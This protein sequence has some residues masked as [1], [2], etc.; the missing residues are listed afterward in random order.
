MNYIIAYSLGFA[1]TGA[2]IM[3]VVLL[4]A[5]IP[6]GHTLSFRS[7]GLLY[8]EHNIFY[9]LNLIPLFLGIAG[10]FVGKKVL[11]AKAETDKKISSY[12]LTIDRAI[13]FVRQIENGNLKTP[14]VSINGEKVLAEALESMRT[15]LIT[16]SQKE[17]ERNEINRISN[18][19]STLLQSFSDTGRLSEEIITFLVNKINNVVQGAFYLIE[20]EKDEEKII[21]MSSSYAYNRKK[22]LHAEFKFA[23]GLVGQAVAEKDSVLRTEIPDDY[24]TI[25]SGL[26]GDQKPRCILIMPCI[27]NDIVYCVIELAS[28]HK[29]DSF[30]CNLVTELSKIIARAIANVEINQRTYTLFKESEKMS[31]ELRSQKKQLMK[32]TEDLITTQEELKRSNT[33]L[34]EQIQE[35]HNTSKRT[36]V[37]LENAKEVITIISADRKILY[38]SPSIKAI[39]GYYPEELLGKDDIENVHPL[40]TQRFR[41]LLKDLKSFPEKELTLQYRYFTK[42]G[43]V[44]WMEAKGKNLLS[45]EVIRGFVI[46]SSDISEQR[47]AA[48]EQRMRAKMQ[49]LSENSSDIII[50][51]DIF[52]RCTYIN[53]VIEE[54]TGVKKEFYLDKPISNTQMDASVVTILKNL[55]EEA[56]VNRAKKTAEMEFP[57]PGGRKVMQVNAIPEFN[58]NGEPE[59]VL[60]AC[61]DITEAKS[62]EELIRKK[63]KNIS[64]SINYAFNIQS[65][66]MP[67][68][69]NFHKVLPNSFMFYKPKDVV[70]GDYPWLYK[71]ENSIFVGAMDCTG[72]GV[73]GALMSIIGFFLQSAIMNQD[74]TLNAGEVLTRLHSSVVKILKQEEANSKINDGMDAAFCKI[75][76]KEKVLDFAGAHR[77]LYYVSKGVLTEIRGDKFPVGGTQ[78][79]NRKDFVNHSIKIQPGDAVYFMTDGFTDQFGG[80]TGKQR[81]TSERVGQLIQE[82]THLSI[83]QMGNLFRKTYDDWKGDVNQLDDVLVIGLKF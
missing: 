69:L 6:Q 54:Y 29:F 46:N 36:Q 28:F 52:S 35:V 59:S 76:L 51:I 38:V 14:Y 56:S 8:K 55:L 34:E 39:M 3:I 81:F 20:G 83:F 71:F 44:I 31:A 61:H 75:N 16:V 72:H 82:N 74:N 43:D 41:Q 40:D 65:A 47:M 64:D 17:Y 53:P 60:F 50:R 42:G 58:E 12:E 62:R 77:P 15:S 19:I 1:L 66:L 27:T 80:P 11:K 5:L 9:L 57:T 4:F 63:N 25:K 33:K 18:E 37:M 7:F 21:R 48:K 13:E 22:Y 78:Y 2:I 68:E 79:R 49:A 67:A 73:P 23:Q 32:N 30:Q 70:S 10:A 24:M 26:L 45:D